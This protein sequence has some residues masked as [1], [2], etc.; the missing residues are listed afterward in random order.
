MRNKV[1]L[2]SA[3]VVLLLVPIFA[4]CAPTPTV[5][6]EK[7]IEISFACFTPPTSSLGMT[8]EYWAKRVEEVTGGR[9]KVNRYWG[10]T[11]LKGPKIYEGV[12]SHIADTGVSVIGFTPGRFPLWQ[13]MDISIGFRS[14]HVANRVQWEVFQKFKPEEWAETHVLVLFAC[15]P[16]SI[17]SNT[18]IR[19]VDDMKGLEIRS[20]G[21]TAQMVEALGGT[22]VGAPQA[23]AYEMLQ[24]G[25]VDGAWSSVDV[26]MGWKQAEVTKYLTLVGSYVST[27]FIV[28]N[29]DTWNSLPKDIQ[30]SIDGLAEEVM[31][32]SATSWERR[33]NEGLQYARDHG[34]EIITLSPAEMTRWNQALKPVL[35]D[36]VARMEAEGLPGREFLDEILKL[37]E[38]YGK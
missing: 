7:P 16:C 33:H 14:A 11:L 30:K 3:A 38:K 21:F 9:I 31:E 29:L 32:W 10:G 37:K 6:P 17:W 22:P 25:I 1:L 18:A 19:S 35:D 12:V 36:Y 13:A 15:T 20:T 28:M 23:E 8:S 26:L 5:T 34:L 24:K 27:F 2:I 4:G